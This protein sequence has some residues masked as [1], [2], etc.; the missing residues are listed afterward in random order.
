[1]FRP[2][3][4]P[5]LRRRVMPALEH[6]RLLDDIKVGSLI[7]VGSNRGQFALL[8]RDRFPSAPIHAFEPL[9]AEA[10]VVKSVIAAPLICHTLALG[11]SAG[12]ATFYVTSKR[13][14]SSL[15]KPGAVQTAASGITLTSATKVR[16]AR[17]SEVIDIKTLPRPILMKIDV[18]GGELD[19]LKGAEDALQ[20]IEAI[21]TEVSFVTLYEG[22]PLASE[23]TTFLHGR[24]FELRGVYN[25]FFAAGVGPTQ[26]DFLYVRGAPSDSVK[27]RTTG[28]AASLLQEPA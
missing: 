2:A 18:Q 19:V 22:Q 12:E 27:H 9:P 10:D 24:G 7:D 17:L 25:H 23:I 8:V 15:F 16:V 28:S 13:D 6:G 11:A 21:Y 14:S 5:A 26:A 4:W 20:L 1:M 3:F